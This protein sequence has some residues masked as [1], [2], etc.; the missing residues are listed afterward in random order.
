MFKFFLETRP[1]ELFVLFLP[2]VHIF[3][4]Y[5]SCFM[6]QL[7]KGYMA[8]GWVWVGAI[9][10]RRL[11]LLMVQARQWH[12]V[13]WEREILCLVLLNLSLSLRTQEDHWRRD[14]LLVF[15]NLSQNATTQ[16]F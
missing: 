4:V 11:C 12:I 9:H 13:V 3:Y 6:T 2:M 5:L 1:F 10:T 14:F 15:K 7:Q 8:H 16:G